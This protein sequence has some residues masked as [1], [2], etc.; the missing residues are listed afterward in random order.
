MGYRNL[1][2]RKGAFNV[3]EKPKKKE[4]ISTIDEYQEAFL[5][6]LEA[7][8]LRQRK[9]VRWNFLTDNEGMFQVSRAISPMMKTNER[10]YRI[11]TKAMGDE[12][13]FWT[14]LKAKE[15][16][17]K[18]KERDYIEGFDEIAKGIET[19]KHELGTSLGELL[20]MGTDILANTNF[21][22]D[23]QKMMDKQ[24]PDEPETWRGDLA[25]L[26]VTYGAPGTVIYK[27]ANRAKFLQPVVD[28]LAKTKLHKASKIAQRMATN[29]VALGATDALVSPDQR[30]LP[31]IF[32]FA[33]PKDVSHLKGRKRAAAMLMNRVRY[34]AEGSIVGG[35][36]PLVG[37]AFQQAYKYAG[38]PVGEPM[39]SMGFNVAGAGF[40]GASYLLTKNPVL[41][42]EVARS[43]VGSTKHGIKKMISP[44]TTKMGLNKLPPFEE[45]NIFSVT[46]PRLHERNL[47]RVDNVL[48]WLRSYG[49][50]P[51]A[52]QG[53]S[54]AVTLFIKGR[55]RKLDKTLE[56]IEKRAYNLAKKYEQRHK[57][58][59]TSRP[60]EKMLKDDIVDYLQGTVKLGQVHKELRPAAY[61]LKKDINKT[62]VE[63]GKN[64][65]QGT[66][67]EVLED[68]RKT[69]TKKIDNYLVRSFAT[70]TDPKYTPLKA[71]R[72]DARNWIRDN[73]VRRNKDLRE[74][75]FNTY[76][77]RFPKTYLEKYAD[78]LVDNVLAKG[79]T[80]GV[81]PVTVLREIGTKLLRQD[82]YQFLKTGE[83]LPDAIKKLLGK[84]K[85][86]K[87]QVLFTVSDT[88]ASNA[89]VKGF[90]MIANVGLKNGWLFKTPE[91]AMTK[92]TN[93]VQIGKIER[94]GALK[95]E[96]EQLYTS[97]ELKQV[98]LATGA[99]LDGFAKTAVI[100]QLLQFKVAVQAGK[101]L[102]SPQ[103]QVRNVTSA[104]FFALWNGHIGHNASV[105]D[106]FRMMIKDIFRAGKG[107]PISE[108]EFSK[109][110]EK[111][112]RLG[113]YDE[114]IVAQ[115]LRAVM[116]NLK[117]GVIR[118]DDDL[119]SA[120]TKFAR[121]E[122]VARLYAGGDNLWKGYGYE[123]F[124]SDL[125]AALKSIDDVA[126]YFKLHNHPWSR[127]DLMTGATK[128][129]D[130]ALDD[131][132]AFM[133]R[134][135]YPTY[136]KV[137]PV[138]QS[139]RNIPFF[140]NF[141]SFQAEML[142]TGTLSIAMSLRNIGTGNPVLRQMGYKNLMGAALAMKGIGTAFS[143]T[144]NF[145]TG[146]TQ[147]Q[148]EAYKRSS[149]APWDK[150]SNL[151][152]ITPWK[153]G[154]S[155][156]VNFSYFS[157]YDVLEGPIQ[158]AL[159]MAHKESIAPDQLENYVLSLMFASDGPIM[160]LMEP[161]MTPA[162]GLERVL[163]VVGGD[164]L[165][166]GRSGR[167]AD[168]K[169]IYSPTDSLE[170]KFNKS[171]VHIVK[172]ASPGIVASGMKIKD[173]IQ[174]D[175]SGAGK[176]MRLRD[177]ML[178]LFTGT[179]IIRIDV[180]KDLKWIAA[181]TNRLL[182]AVDETEKFYKAKE[183]MNRPPSIMVAEFEKMQ[184]EAFEIQRDLYMK[185][186][187]MQML[188]LS[189]TKI[190]QILRKA[191][192]N[193]KLVGNLMR[194]V[195]TPIRY[196][197]SRFKSKIEDVK[198]VAEHLTEKSDN[199]V[200]NVDKNFLFPRMELDRTRRK[201]LNKKFFPQTYNEE[202]KQWE[203]GYK[204]ELEGA[205]TNDKGNVVYDEKGKI[206]R[207]PGIIQKGWE[208]IKPFVSPISDLYRS[209]TPLP[210]TPGVNQEL[211]AQ[212]TPD[213]S[214]TGLTHTETALL[215]NEE[216]AMR[217]RQRGQA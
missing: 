179:R 138:I 80:A 168:G 66:K 1:V 180:K 196:S 115:E 105:A 131:A 199:W 28:A 124:K 49:K 88:I 77:N 194:G 106:S 44:I 143:T 33:E 184:T 5:K 104:S 186:K 27:I 65:P 201:Y 30:R 116:K 213:I 174:G 89:S 87:S 100:R 215:S 166:G 135:S 142:R 197:K 210:P 22:R 161:F 139:L 40:K 165:S 183:Y 25:A 132:A 176:P 162:I 14:E 110:V 151:I 9:P 207:E 108:V 43:L 60:Y 48:S 95:S 158:A 211:V 74:I 72:I 99:P 148:W 52:I 200:Y 198:G 81:N 47:K 53:I 98:L 128:S 51:K 195:F 171:W 55:A 8:E 206:K 38:R 46:S 191:G 17:L 2:D 50:L 67:S 29:A 127:K 149:A 107:D 31:T 75:A 90:N 153:D 26:M 109:Y 145:L 96:L 4:P 146:N 41:H 64:L 117:E 192:M 42:S 121:T 163:D 54:E 160:E 156:A 23:F 11:I 37:K 111:L 169:Y 130:E 97:P 10:L 57:T 205:V 73:V 209:Q 91:Q 137:P 136:S 190:S 216:K 56:N 58:N 122:K 16:R 157:P 154:E 93:P 20:F 63:F 84:E 21:Q 103:T 141:V 15:F 79:R 119:F 82:K 113:V 86:L 70:F 133:L 181:E 175:V 202:T 68:L 193:K 45:W 155:A 187:D 34:G 182:R 32:K 61:E 101:T 71:V 114:N 170:D 208:K 203:G 144:A 59:N 62:L 18:S 185:I 12:K 172:G 36:F 129:L 112:I 126:A 167:T 134:N 217:L 85:D 92:F 152:G 204:P 102:Y 150:N 212:A 164:F 120:L 188:D 178:A 7:Y 189:S 13:P 214:Q 78:D 94:L 125:S 3:Y 39:L 35:V 76:H 123:F 19:G 24:K 177:E 140:G 159:T 6:S 83:E 69:F 147:E 173:A 118:T